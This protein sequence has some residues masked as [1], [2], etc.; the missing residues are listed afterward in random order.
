MQESQKGGARLE[1]AFESKE[2]RDICESESEAVRALGASVAEMLKHRLADLDAAPSAKD[3]IAG[4]PRLSQ[5]E[6][7]MMVDLSEGSR[8]VFTP[9]HPDNPVTETGKLDWANVR[10]I[11]I[12]RIE[13]DRA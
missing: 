8:L 11:R 13:N 1:F 7:T 4:R 9:N 10:R 5:D 6:E 2:L 3:L 12:L